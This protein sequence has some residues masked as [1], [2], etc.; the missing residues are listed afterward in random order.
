LSNVI[1]EPAIGFRTSN[2]PGTNPGTC[3]AVRRTAARLRPAVDAIALI[4]GGGS[5]EDLWSFNEEVLVRAVAAAPVPIVSGVGHEIDVTLCDLAAD[6]RAL[7]PTDAAVKLVPDAR[8]VTAAVVGLGT[9]LQVSLTRRLEF[10]RDRLTAVGRSR[11][12]AD[13]SRLVRDRRD[14]I[15]AHALRLRRLA[16]SVVS[17]AGE[18]VAAAAAR[19][20]AGSPVHLLARGWSVTKLDGHDAA[21]K[22]TAG[23]AAGATIITQLADGRLWSRV[24][25]STD[26]AI[27]R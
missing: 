15:D 10:A 21:L 11:M 1:G 25:R 12:F 7:T 23:I 13:P 26:D 22:S 24:E 5:L 3:S 17:R 16:G 4:R 9:R 14:A 18:R 8:Q 2:W 6:V 19:L 20:E 27:K